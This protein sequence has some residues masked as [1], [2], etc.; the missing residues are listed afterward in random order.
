LS[1]DQTY[2][3]ENI[4]ESLQY[5]TTDPNT[6]PNYRMYLTTGRDL[7]RKRWQDLTFRAQAR[8][9]EAFTTNQSLAYDLNNNNWR[10]L[11]SQFGWQRSEQLIFN[12]GSRY[13]IE[14]SRLRRVSTELSWVISPKWRLQWLGGYDGISNE[15][16]YNEFL[17]TRDLHCW[18]VSLYVSHQLQYQYLY[19]RLKAL[20]MPLP[21]FGIGRAGQ[22]LDTT[23]GTTN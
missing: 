9:A 15:L 1:F 23:M 3:Y 11:V 21:L 6:T 22:V 7:D 19:V 16:L 20:N 17:V 8:L 18:D 10:D 5:I 12:L 4:T 13:D 14:G 2:P